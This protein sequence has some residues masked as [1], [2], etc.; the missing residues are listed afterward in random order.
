MTATYSRTAKILHWLIAGLIVLQYVL[1]RIAEVAEAN[2]ALLVQ[3]AVL[4][5]HKS[6][7]MT[8]L[9]LA[10]IRV[11]WRLRYPAPS[12]PS[13]MPQWQ[14]ALSFVA[15]F[16]LYALLFAMPITG[17]LMSSATAYSVSWFNLFTFPDLVAPSDSLAESMHFWHDMLG[18]VLFALALVHILAAIKHRIVDRDDVLQRM[19]SLPMVLLFI[20]TFVAGV[21]I[22]ASPNTRTEKSVAE[23]TAQTSTAITQANE[24]N[25]NLPLRQSALPS[26]NIDYQQSEIRFAGDQAGAPFEGV[27]QR[28]QANLKFD[29]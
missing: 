23:A 17:W 14:Q 3:L 5:N 24:G 11:I 29:P 6:A 15:H 7:G 18:R 27:W 16:L 1:N 8:V 2:D 4:A 10:V 13:T 21:L 12:L 22:L 26:W 9:G 20:A 28:W 25:Q 19:A